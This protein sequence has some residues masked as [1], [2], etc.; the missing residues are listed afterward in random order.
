MTL[1]IGR[2]P[3][4]QRSDHDR[5]LRRLDWRPGSRVTGAP[6]DAIVVPAA[7]RASH[8]E[9]LVRLAA[10]C[11]TT[12]VVLASHQ[13]EIDEV[14]A[15]VA[16]TPGSGRVVLADISDGLDHELG[17]RATSGEEFRRHNGGRSS[18]L[19]L[20]RNIGL[21]LARFRGWTKIMFLD[22]DIIGV[23]PDHIA[24]VAHHLDSNRFAG[25]KT[26]RFEDNSVVCHANRLAGRPQG[27]F[28]A[29][30]AVGVNTAM[31]TDLEVFPDIYNEDWFAFAA[32][33]EKSGVAHVGNVRQ[34]EF[35]PFADPR[36]AK[37]EEFGD[38]I[39][40]GLYSLLSNGQGI[41]R[42]TVSHWA[43]FIGQ[44]WE[45]INYI[46][47][48]LEEDTAQTHQRVQAVVSLKEALSQLE[49]IRAEHCASFIRAWQDDR[50]WFIAET[51]AAGGRRHD[52][53]DAFAALGLKRW[54]EA[55]FGIS[56]MPLHV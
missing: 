21:L 33:A 24:R 41:T 1:I 42:A 50:Q 40:E 10:R 38:L 7:R 9:G 17:D 3:V 34:I 53:G 49:S 56:K 48:Q 31:T 46:A 26:L 13:C 28:V 19:S 15:L 35:N 54:Q 11:G 16:S 6:L 22:D 2:R 55:R 12:L 4:G 51:R 47:K 45:L 44:R 25:L 5:L 8:L 29:G 30:A 43:G 18:N 20:K 37:Y 14:A 39:A 52:Y 27:I 23:T 32:E 36:R